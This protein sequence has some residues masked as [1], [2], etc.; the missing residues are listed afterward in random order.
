MFKKLIVAGL[1]CACAGQLLADAPC[2]ATACADPCCDVFSPCSACP[3]APAD[4][5]NTCA[6]TQPAEQNVAA[7]ATPETHWQVVRRGRDVCQPERGTQVSDWGFPSYCPSCDSLSEYIRVRYGLSDE[8]CQTAEG[9]LKVVDALRT[10]IAK[11]DADGVKGIGQFMADKH[12]NA[13]MR[14]ML[15]HFD[16]VHA[17]A[18]RGNFFQV[19]LAG[20]T[21]MGLLYAGL[22]VLH[23]PVVQITQTQRVVGGALLGGALMAGCCSAAIGTEKRRQVRERAYDTLAA[24]L[25]CQALIVGG[26]E[27]EIDHTLARI[28]K[29]F[30]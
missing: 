3:V 28:E 21:G 7:Q 20:L 29:R 18:S 4:A 9:K 25:D 11:F 30:N 26:D 1:L 5:C 17:R 22:K 19:C 10:A 12:I 6:A 2:C 8:S 15:K 14:T 16:H 13:P 23:K 24:L 27:R